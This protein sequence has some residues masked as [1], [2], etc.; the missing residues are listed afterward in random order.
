MGRRPVLPADLLLFTLGASEHPG[1]REEGLGHGWLVSGLS[2]DDGA[3][4]T[5]TAV[6]AAGLLGISVMGFKSAAREWSTWN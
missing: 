2:D 5:G 6:Q 3:G 4:A 1:G